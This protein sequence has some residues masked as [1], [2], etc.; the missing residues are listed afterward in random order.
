MN[1]R[2][3][4]LELIAFFL[5]IAATHLAAAA[6]QPRAVAGVI[7]LT[8]QDLQRGVPLGGEWQFSWGHLLA[9]ADFA[10]GGSAAANGL[11]TIEV[12]STWG[13]ASTRYPARG[14]ATYRL[15]VNLPAG[16][17]QPIG[18]TLKRVGTA[19]RLYC[20]GALVL[21][22]GTVS[23]DLAGTRGSYASRV[24]YVRG[25]PR[26]EIVL[27]V[28]NADD[29]VAGVQESPVIGLQGVVAFASTWE[30]LR[31]A[32]LYAAIL[33]MGL[34]HLLLALLHP[35][36]RAS[37]WFGVLAV[38]LTVRGGLTGAR[39]LHQVA[40]AA[41]FHALVAAEFVTVYVAGLAV[42]LFFHDL[43]P[44]E[45]P[46]FVLGP[47][48]GVTVAMSVVAIATPL[49]TLVAVHTW[50]EYLLLAEGVLLLVWLVRS[51][52][53][54]R[55]GTPL[56][57]AGFVVLLASA[58]YD[59]VLNLTRSTGTF[60]TSY[61][62]VVFVFLQAGSIARRSASAYV[63]AVE[64]SR[65]S[66]ALAQ[67]FSRFV[68]R[69]FLSL[70]G[71]DSIEHVRLGD[72]VAL[73]LTVLFADIRAFTTLSEALTPLENFNFLNSYLSRISPVVRSNRGFIDKYLGDGVMAL[74][75]RSPMDAVRAGLELM[76]TVRVFNGHR[77]RAGYRP[78]SIG[79]GINTGSLM[80]GTIGES[81][82]MEGTVISD[83]VNLASRLEG[84]T[85]TF[86][87]SVIVSENLL[88]ACPEAQQ[89][90]HRCLGRVRV[91]GKQRGVIVYEIIDSPDMARSQTRRVFEAALAAFQ[92][93]RYA[94][95]AQG[96]GSVAETDPAD[97]AARF[98]LRRI[99]ALRP[100]L[101]RTEL[102]GPAPG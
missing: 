78:I 46:R 81:N 101:A 77:A 42:F 45:R 50:Y 5:V 86:G 74:F 40:A 12:P 64:Q 82:R 37:L 15:L 34:Y 53:A 4:R 89:L 100:G 80:L 23:A 63:S 21:E 93:G 90:P 88:A 27:Q 96:F 61:A 52:V 58:V 35:G 16:V 11:T 13:T 43:F 70:L 98:Y 71:K 72:Q 19:Y 32:I 48:L 38:D 59:I 75:P 92:K 28:A 41:G 76:D 102:V 95:A 87:A 66:E 18:L 17:D 24:V 2:R 39:L 10:S 56:V 91:K 51:L 94:E 6:A 83:A 29:V 8:E 49:G 36:E 7:S 99:Q 31:D 79:V 65:K 3:G 55:D 30:N 68:P 33:M 73:D 84:L 22:N 44:Q 60:L 26:L 85:R 20:N 62:M 69:E 14:I 9:P 47:L 25:G 54:R 1:R 97:S 67:S 57:L